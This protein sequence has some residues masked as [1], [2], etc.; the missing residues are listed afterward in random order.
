MFSHRK[1]GP[2]G[3]SL[4]KTSANACLQVIIDCTSF[5]MV[6][7]LAHSTE[8]PSCDYDWSLRQLCSWLIMVRRRSDAT[9]C[10]MLPSNPF[11]VKSLLLTVSCFRCSNTLELFSCSADGTV[12]YMSFSNNEIGTPIG[13]K[14]KAHQQYAIHTDLQL[15]SCDFVYFLCVSL[16]RS[17]CLRSDMAQVL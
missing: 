9:K 10:N 7:F 15:K 8:A 4:G 14:D 3:V 17:F 1:Q 11:I 5:T 13:K 16:F 12:A 6:W 2:I